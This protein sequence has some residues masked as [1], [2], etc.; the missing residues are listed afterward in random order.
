LAFHSGN[1]GPRRS[2]AVGGQCGSQLVH[3]SAYAGKAAFAALHRGVSS[4]GG[5]ATRQMG[6]LGGGNHFIEVCVEQG[7]GD[8][9]RVW[10]MLHS[11]RGTSARSWPGG[12]SRSP[13]IC[14]TT[15][16][17]RTGNLAVFV[18]GTPEWTPTG[19]TLRERRST[20]PAT[21]R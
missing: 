2:T 19:P 15:R 10:L 9:G 1:T 5:R 14:R 11:A 17:S 6:T 8:A 3:G 4:L 13:G 12:S 18:S 16:T 7:G 21:V 20:P